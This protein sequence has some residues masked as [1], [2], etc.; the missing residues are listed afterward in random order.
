M[1]LGI[2]RGQRQVF[3]KV[4]QRRLGHEADD[5]AGDRRRAVLGGQPAHDRD[6]RRQRNRHRVVDVGRHLCPVA[7]LDPDGAH[8]ADP[9]AGFA[10]LG[11]DRAGDLD[12][13]GVE[14]EVEG[15]ERRAGRDQRRAGARVRLGRAEVRRQLARA[16]PL[17]QLGEAAAAEVAALRPPRIGGELAIE[18]D[19]DPE[20]GDRERRLERQLARGRALGLGDPDKRTDVERADAGMGALVCAHVDSL[21]TRLGAGDQRAVQRL[22]GRG[23][24]QHGAVVDLVGV[25]VEQPGATE[26][27]ADRRDR[28]RVTAL[29][30]VGDGERH[31]E[32]LSPRPAARPRAPGVRRRR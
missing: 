32:G 13:R 18:E 1:Q 28:V 6:H 23:Q 2:E 29:G 12:V 3:G 15:G 30:E 19:R 25:A 10:Q 27:G 16:H 21:D 4:A 31:G 20:V 14:L 24:G 7:E 9:A 8:A 22:P 11:G 5:L 26:R 17:R